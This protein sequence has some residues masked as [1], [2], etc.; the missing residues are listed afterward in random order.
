MI[1]FLVLLIPLSRGRGRKKKPQLTKKKKRLKITTFSYK[2][3]I[4]YFVHPLVNFAFRVRNQ[5]LFFSDT[6][7]NSRPE[8]VCNI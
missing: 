5:L 7:S 4:H 3:T 6:S 2:L 8:I 1:F